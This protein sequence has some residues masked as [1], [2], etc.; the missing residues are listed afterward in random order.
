MEPD[1]AFFLTRPAESGTAEAVRSANAE[2]GRYGLSLTE[3]QAAELLEARTEALRAC[4]RIEFG[5]GILP[6]LMAAFGD[7][8]FLSQENW[9]E[10]L[11]TLQEAF[12]YFKGEAAEALSDDEL[13][14]AMKA[15]FDGPAQGSADYLTGT[16]L[17]ELCRRARNG[18]D[19]R[20]GDDAEALF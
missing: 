17:E 13:V 1:P 19:P 8:P 2:T 10:T 3:A 16:S 15:V 9:A 12:Y 5:V 18:F 7:S 11:G 20:D 6:K 4:G 14:A